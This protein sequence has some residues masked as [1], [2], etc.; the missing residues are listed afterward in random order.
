MTKNSIVI[1]LISAFTFSVNTS[2]EIENLSDVQIAFSPNGDALN[3][4][5][6]EINEARNSIKVA[7]YAFTSE[8]ISQALIKAKK[9]GVKVQLVAD[10][11]AN[12][13][14]YTAV[15]FLAN[16][17][18]PVRLNDRYAIMHNKFMIFDDKTLQ[19]GSFNYSKAAQ[20]SNA[21]N[22]IIIKNNQEIAKKY[23][24]N[25]EKLWS[26]SKSLKPKY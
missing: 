18:V 22:V 15:T 21:E 24:V 23:T 8:P 11:K 5:I 25:F 9:R 16:Q 6:N 2:A 3:I 17:G 12:S 10:K 4:I 20:K 7:A 13:K 1:L 14:K 19:T 26:E